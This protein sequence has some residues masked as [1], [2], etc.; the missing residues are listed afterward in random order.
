MNRVEKYIPKII[1]ILSREYGEKIPKVYNAYIAS[2]STSVAM[3]GLIATVAL[4]EDMDKIKNNK[5]Q[6]DKSAITKII[7]EVLT[8]KK[9]SLLKYLLENNE[10][11]LKRKILDIAIAFKLAIRTFELED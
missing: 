6:K 5:T 7:M 11:K 9:D 8:G 1:E 3:N 4:Y 2:F 10:K